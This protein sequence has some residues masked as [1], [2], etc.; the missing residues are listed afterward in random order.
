MKLA[1]VPSDD[2]VRHLLWLKQKLGSSLKEM[3][4]VTAGRYAYRRKDGVA[5][6]PAALLGP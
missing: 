3:V 1:D 4:V 6:V 2:D 5:V